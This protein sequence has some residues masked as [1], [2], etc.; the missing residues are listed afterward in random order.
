[1]D[2]SQGTVTKNAAAFF[3]MTETVFCS[4][5]VAENKSWRSDFLSKEVLSA[6]LKMQKL[7]KCD[8]AVEANR[9]ALA[10]SRSQYLNKACR[11]VNK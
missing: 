5:G 9:L 3:S 2:F 8:M 4:A 6:L 11:W 7:A 1:L 10:W